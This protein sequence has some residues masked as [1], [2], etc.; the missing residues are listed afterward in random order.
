[1][2]GRAYLEKSCRGKDHDQCVCQIPNLLLEGQILDARADTRTAFQHVSHQHPM[3]GQE[4]LTLNNVVASTAH[5][6]RADYAHR[7]G[8]EVVV[9]LQ[10]V[11]IAW[12]D[13]QLWIGRE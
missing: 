7:L 5:D 13:L 6:S 12:P 4:P 10:R 3:V 9:L 1:M 11:W 2:L 8:K